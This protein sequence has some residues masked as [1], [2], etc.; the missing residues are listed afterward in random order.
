MS[1]VHLFVFV[2]ITGPPV[3]PKPHSQRHHPGAG[4]PENFLQ[5]QRGH[6]MLLWEE[7]RVRD[8][9]GCGLEGKT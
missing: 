9:E 5:S 8:P 2:Y 7:D 4:H 1:V 3:I 6:L